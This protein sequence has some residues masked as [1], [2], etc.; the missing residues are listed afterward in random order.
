MNKIT[1]GF[2]EFLLAF[3]AVMLSHNFAVGMSIAGFATFCAFCRYAMEQA[4]KN[5][6]AEQHKEAAR[7]LN[8]AAGEVGGAFAEIMAA[9]SKGNGKNKTTLH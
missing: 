3:A 8:E 6:K 2:S 7:V 1:V 5:K 9:L 4:E